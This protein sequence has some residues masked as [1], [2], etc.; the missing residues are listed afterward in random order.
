MALCRPVGENGG[1]TAVHV[2][3]GGQQYQFVVLHKVTQMFGCL[4]QLCRATV[5]EPTERLGSWPYHLAVT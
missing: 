2:L 3:R 1:L 4:A 5:T